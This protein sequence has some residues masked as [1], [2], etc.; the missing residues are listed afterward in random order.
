MA[1]KATCLSCGSV[2]NF[3]DQHA[4]KKVKCKKCDAVIAVPAVDADAEGVMDVRANDEE[5]RSKKSRADDRDDEMDDRD[6][7]DD[8][9]ARKS[10][11]APPK[12]S[13]K[14]LFIILGVVGGVLLLCCGGSA[15][16]FVFVANKTADAVQ[17][18]AKKMDEMKK[19]QKDRPFIDEKV[20]GKIVLT[21]NDKINPNDPEIDFERTPGFKEK[22]KAKS[23]NVQFTQGKTY[24]INMKANPGSPIDPF[25][26]LSDPT[27][28]WL[29]SDDDG[30]GFPNARIQHTAMM[31][32]QFRIVATAFNNAPGD[33]TLTVEER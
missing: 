21:Q 23:Y 5:R 9:R 6:D 10:S 20:I 33:Y 11:G 2:F 27:G 26:V 31:N 18:V 8:R 30:G 32:G 19:A 13:N 16:F 15:I 29:F 17:Q 28:K 12:S 25:L 7:G 4:G 24:V 1:I 22:K 3:G 14:T